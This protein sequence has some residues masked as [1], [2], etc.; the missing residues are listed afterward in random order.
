MR[1]SAPWNCECFRNSITHPSHMNMACTY[2]TDQTQCFRLPDLGLLFIF[3]ATVDA[4]HVAVHGWNSE[5]SR[6]TYPPVRIGIDPI[7]CL[8]GDRRN[9][10]EASIYTF[11][12]GV[13]FKHETPISWNVQAISNTTLFP[14]HALSRL[15][16]DPQSSRF[17]ERTCQ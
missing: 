6:L 11:H 5:S 15:P 10:Y 13:D 3:D 12:K 4:V 7:N 8:V 2:T 14:F 16:D 1:V 17:T 9:D